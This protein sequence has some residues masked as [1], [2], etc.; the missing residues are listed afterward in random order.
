LLHLHGVVRCA[1]TLGLLPG[2]T[3]LGAAH[4]H[5]HALLM[6]DGAFL[7]HAR[8]GSGTIS[9]CTHWHGRTNSKGGYKSRHNSP[10]HPMFLFVATPS[11]ETYSQRK[12]SCLTKF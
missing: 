4:P 8:R 9:D 7:V 5:L 6:G 1:P 10:F 11:N 12:I 2:G 3:A